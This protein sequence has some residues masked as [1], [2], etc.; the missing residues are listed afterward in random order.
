MKKISKPAAI[1]KMKA[2]GARKCPFGQCAKT[3][4]NTGDIVCVPCPGVV[5]GI[6]TSVGGSLAILSKMA[7][8]GIKK[9]K[10]VT[11]IKKANPNMTR[12]E[13]RKTY[14]KQQ[15]EKA[16]AAGKKLTKAQRGMSTSSVRKI[17]KSKKK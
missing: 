5:G 8:D 12:K 13:A 1:K 10:E 16:N 3:D 9:G 7:K 15:D 2:G 4:N 11:A 17:V 14:I 6:A